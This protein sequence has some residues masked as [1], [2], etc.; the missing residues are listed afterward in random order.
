MKMNKHRHQWL[1]THKPTN[2]NKHEYFEFTCS[3]FMCGLKKRI[4]VDEYKC[5]LK[6]ERA[7]IRTMKLSRQKV[8]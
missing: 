6:Y 8:T 5:K 3:Y 1:K 7:L 4:Y 2:Y